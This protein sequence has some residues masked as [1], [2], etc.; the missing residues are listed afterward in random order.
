VASIAYD[1]LLLAA[2]LAGLGHHI[3]DI[4]TTEFPKL[5]QVSQ[6]LRFS[7]PSPIRKFSFDFS[8]FAWALEI[9]YTPA[10][11][12]AK[13]SLLF[14]LI[15]IFTPMKSGLVYWAC[16]A[17][18]WGNLAFYVSILFTLIFE[19]HPIKAVWAQFYG[20]QCIN[21][22]MVLLV[23]GAVNVFSDFLNILLPIWATWHLQMAP[24]RK[25]GIIAVFATGLL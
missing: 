14:Q 15:R 17:L 24:K 22:N 12:L 20:N 19:C 23:S 8:Q 6:G 7:N 13:A 5:A 2:G 11:W 25:A 21:R 3:W 18:I 10:I 9:L 4:P 1:F 16:H